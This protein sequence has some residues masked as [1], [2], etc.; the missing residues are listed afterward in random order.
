NS[1]DPWGL[2]QAVPPSAEAAEKDRQAKAAMYRALA[3]GVDF[4][5]NLGVAV[6]LTP[7][8]EGMTE[9]Q[10]Y[11]LS[12]I[13]I[14]QYGSPLR[15][16]G[17]YDEP[18]AFAEQLPQELGPATQNAMMAWAMKPGASDFP[19]AP[20]V[21]WVQVGQEPLLLAPPKFGPFYRV[22]GPDEIQ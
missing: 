19:Q 16:M 7:S 12:Q 14:S 10:W 6:F 8:P 3:K 13:A 5:W 15:R 2:A 20:K 9:K 11:A 17:A 1:L 21:E 4:T 22:A 18:S